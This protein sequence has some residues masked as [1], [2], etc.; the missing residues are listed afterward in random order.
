MD[1][2]KGRKINASN[3][4]QNILSFL[5]NGSYYLIGFIPGVINQ[6][7]GLASVIEKLDTCRFYASS[8]LILYDADWSKEIDI[9][10]AEISINPDESKSY[11]NVLIKMIDFAHS[12]HNAHL[13][14]PL[15]TDISKPPRKETDTAESAYSKDQLIYCTYP[16]TTKGP[17]NGYLKGLNSL[18]H[19]F[20]EIQSD[21]GGSLHHVKKNSVSRNVQIKIDVC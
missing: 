18:I 1:K 20:E 21:F 11:P 9:T 4:K 13:L 12:I 17:D 16:P 8:L 3:F 6:L 2:Y 15:Q 7:K 14:R 5:D 19:C 10:K